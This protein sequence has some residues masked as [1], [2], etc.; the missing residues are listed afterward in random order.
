MCWGSCTNGGQNAM[1]GVNMYNSEEPYEPATRSLSK[2]LHFDHNTFYSADS[3][4]QN[5]Y[6]FT[7]QFGSW[8]GANATPM[9]RWSFTSSILPRSAVGFVRNDSF[10]NT[11][12]ATS[13][14]TFETGNA[15]M[16]NNSL[17]GALTSL[18]CFAGQTCARN[19]T[20][21]TSLDAEFMSP[22]SG[23]LK[24]APG[25]RFA[26]GGADGLDIGADFD[27]LAV[28][29][30]FTVSPGF[31]SARLDWDLT[32]ANNQVPCVLEVS[33]SRNLFSG[34]GFYNVVNTLNPV[35]F[36]QPDSDVSTNPKLI[37]PIVTG[38]HRTVIVGQRT[39]VADDNDGTLRD[40][41]LSA[42]TQYW[43]R[44]MCG[45]DTQTF[46]FTTLSPGDTLH[47]SAA[48][49]VSLKLQGPQG[50]SVATLAYGADQTLGQT[51]TATPDA[52]GNV[53]FQV[54]VTLGQATFY[55]MSY[56]V[57]QKTITTQVSS[58]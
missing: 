28:I 24:A 35:Y 46:S 18:G 31:W 10:A 30:G 14:S 51:L 41:A 1:W 26:K 15:V 9:D 27:Q 32:E 3:L 38:T 53:E 37:Q 54:P 21:V 29:A 50:A 5:A 19:L 6:W 34:L 11:Q 12:I 44:L 7:M 48:A 8:S 4:G 39:S 52:S 2:D 23:I 58:F 33:A 16:S 56:T 13:L 47:W 42:G 25:S 49:V 55:R 20:D 40:L 22:A 43:G 45:G 36:H 57:G 17:P